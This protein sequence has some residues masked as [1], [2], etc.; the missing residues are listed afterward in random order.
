MKA[1]LSFSPL[2]LFSFQLISPSLHLTSVIILTRKSLLSFL[3]HSFFPCTNCEGCNYV[4]F[5]ILPV[6][7]LPQIQIS[8]QQCECLI[9]PQSMLVP[10]ND[11]YSLLPTQKKGYSYYFVKVIAGQ[12]FVLG[13]ALMAKRWISLITFMSNNFSFTGF[14][15]NIFHS[16]VNVDESC[17]SRLTCHLV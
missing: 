4:T 7:Q 16:M 1:C 13:F 3:F 11:K 15:T 10:L 6:L 12:T 8:C 14:T 9:N 2:L 5:S 17:R